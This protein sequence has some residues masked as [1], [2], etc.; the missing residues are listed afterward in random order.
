MEEIKKQDRLMEPL[1][2]RESS[3]IGH[4]SPCVAFR[5]SEMRKEDDHS[6]TFFRS[7]KNL[8]ESFPRRKDLQSNAV[9]GSS[10]SSEEGDLRVQSSLLDRHTEQENNGQPT[11]QVRL[12]Q[13]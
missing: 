1:S 9:R 3:R 10:D 4:G 7:E 6:D 2:H 5:G 11:F 12:S 13:Q 8:R